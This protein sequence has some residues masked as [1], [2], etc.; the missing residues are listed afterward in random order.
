MSCFGIF[1]VTSCFDTESPDDRGDEQVEPHEIRSPRKAH[2]KHASKKRHNHRAQSHKSPRSG[3]STPRSAASSPR[4]VDAER[5]ECSL[6]H[7]SGVDWSGLA[8]MLPLEDEYE[9]E[10]VAK[11]HNFPSEDL[12][13]PSKADGSNLLMF[14]CERAARVVAAGLRLGATMGPND[15]AATPRVPRPRT[16]RGDAAGARLDRPRTGSRR[17]PGGNRPRTGRGDAATA[18]WIVRGDGLRRRR[19]RDVDIP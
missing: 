8:A 13:E 19:G 12:L 10:F 3:A 7:P 4:S 14:C 5:I 18:T 9:H 6:P 2:K 16:G 1:D 15:R 17:R 11:L